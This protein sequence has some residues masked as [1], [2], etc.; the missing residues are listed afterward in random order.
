MDINLKRVLHG[1]DYNPEQWP[2]EIHDEDMRLMR[3]AGWNIATLPVFGWVSLQPDEETFRFE[4]LDTLLDKMHANGIAACLATATAATPAWL[5][6]KYP[7]VLRV[8]KNGVRRKH[9]GR[10]TFCPHSPNFRRLSTGLARRLAERYKDHP[11]LAVWH[12][13]NEY[14][15]HCYCDLCA[16]A[17]RE[18][19]KKRYG[20]VEEVNRRWYLHFWGAAITDWSQIETPT[21]NGQR[22]FQ[23]LL[24]D[25][26]RFQSESILECYKAEAGVLRK[27]TPNVPITTNLMGAFK[28]LDY[29]KW[30]R[31]MDIVSWDSYP[32]KDAPPASMAFAHSLMRGLKEGQPWMLME[33][34]PSQQNWQSHN[35][36]KRPGVMRLWSY[37]AMA[38]G[39]ES[40][41]YFQ[42][43]RSRGAQEKYHGAVVE[44]EGTSKPRVFQEVAQLG[45]E[46][47]ALGTRTL[48]GRVPARVAI[49]FDWD[50]WWAIEYSSGPSVDLK[51]VEQ[52]Q[53]YF[54][55]LHASSIPTDIVSPEADLS[56]YD[57]VVAPVLY[58]V[59]DGIADRIKQFVERGGTFVTTFF[60]GIVDENDLVYL[61]GYP[62]PLRELLG[63][64]AEEI[65]ALTPQQSNEVVFETAFGELQGSYP[66]RL[67]C[68]RVHAEG[69]Q[70]LATYSQDFYAGEAA[71]TENRFGSGKAYYLG[72]SL[73]ASTLQLF[74]EKLCK[75]A[76]ITSPLIAVPDGVEVM[77]RISPNGETLLYVLNHNANQI[78]VNLAD[79]SFIDLISGA[80]HNKDI[81]LDSYGVAILSQQ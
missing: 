51:Y 49:L 76:D 5:D 53:N 45:G 25:Y 65:D 36:L 38:H 34:T 72:T 1:G 69:A 14:G 4:W 7:D 62:G 8:E 60:S 3:E 56:K 37:Q 33:Q 50:N 24:I 9:G 64:W 28:P 57:L 31:E 70:V 2:T 47:A 15:N 13:S 39:A 46:L 79:G 10:H 40:I 66:A 16:E 77:E 20:T 27:L 61:G 75:D 55:A 43:R 26:D 67:L 42:W 12:V 81:T 23:G 68:D 48:G 22:N 63:I 21:T 6:Q 41:M 73:D 71:V 19:T 78:T 74:L 80:S 54:N 35:A 59:K 11:A 17:F 29:H 30:A 52:C 44:H 18:W 32:G 58:M